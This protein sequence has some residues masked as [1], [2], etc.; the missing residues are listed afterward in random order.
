MRIDTLT[1]SSPLA[2]TI[3]VTGCTKSYIFSAGALL[4]LRYIETTAK[5]AHLG[6]LL[7]T[8]SMPRVLFL[9]VI[10]LCEFYESG[11]SLNLEI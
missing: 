4:L 11:Y 10:W 2:I 6:G 9:E 5:E 1:W 7:L 8:H 3:P